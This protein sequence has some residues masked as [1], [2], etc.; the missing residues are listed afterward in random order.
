VG[1]VIF[2]VATGARGHT[3]GAGGYIFKISSWGGYGLS[4]W[5]GNR[6]V[7]RELLAGT[8][9]AIRIGPGQANTIF[10]LARESVIKL[11]V[12]EAFVGGVTD[13]TFDAGILGVLAAGLSGPTDVTFKNVRVWRI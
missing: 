6:P 10:I 13:S 7:Y 4:A 11:Y 12:N 1:G 9:S 5:L 8:S 3:A 2:R